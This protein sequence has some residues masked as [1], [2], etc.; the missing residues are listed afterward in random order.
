MVRRLV[1]V[2]VHAHAYVA[3]FG[4][5]VDGAAVG[6]GQCRVCGFRRG[7]EGIQLRRQ[8]VAATVQRGEAFAVMGGSEGEGPAV[9]FGVIVAPH[10]RVVVLG[11]HAPAAIGPAALEEAGGRVEHRRVAGSAV[12]EVVGFGAV[13]LAC[14]GCGRALGQRIGHVG[15]AEVIECAFHRPRHALMHVGAGVAPEGR[16]V[17]ALAADMAVGWYHGRVLQRGGVGLARIEAADALQ[18]RI[19]EGHVRAGAD[20]QVRV[21][22]RRPARDPAASAV[23]LDETLHHLPGIVGR[24]QRVGRPG[25]AE[26]VAEAIVDEHLAIAHGGKGAG[27]AALGVVIAGAGLV[28]VAPLRCGGAAHVFMA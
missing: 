6:T 4:H 11:V 16:T 2:R 12:A 28:G 23:L 20:H 19:G 8:L 3:R 1:A 18:P 7:E 25:G 27:R 13:A 15:D 22:R 21:A 9:G 10:A 26:G 24:E 17:H 5:L 14:G